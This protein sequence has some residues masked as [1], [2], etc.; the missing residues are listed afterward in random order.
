MTQRDVQGN[1]KRIIKRR[2]LFVL[3]KILK[4]ADL[5]PWADESAVIA[6]CA[7]NLSL[8]WPSPGETASSPASHRA[9]I[10]NRKAGVPST[11]SENQNSNIENHLSSIASAKEEESFS[12]ALRL[13][14]DL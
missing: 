10:R 3:R 8:R 11:A 13:C 5:G 4:S 9:Q 12:L 1:S 7:N 6:Y 14:Q 2:G